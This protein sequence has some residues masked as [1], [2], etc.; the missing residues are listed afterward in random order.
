MLQSLKKQHGANHLLLA[1]EDLRI[2]ASTDPLE[3]TL[4]KHLKIKIIESLESKKTVSTGLYFC[5]F[6]ER[7]HIDFISPIISNK[8]KIIAVIVFQF[9]PEDYL[10]PLIQ[11]WP[12]ESKTAETLLFRIESKSVL[13]LNELRHKKNTALKMSIPLSKTEVPAVA[14]ALG[15]RGAY[16]GYDYRGKE[17][18]AYLDEVP[19]TNWYMTAKV[20]TEEIFSQLKF[21]LAGVI[22]F[23]IVLI[24]ALTIGLMWIYHYR[25]KNIYKTLWEKN[26]EFNITLSSIGDA[27]ITTDN[28]GIIYYINPA[29]EDLTGWKLT[30][31]RGEKIER[32]FKIINEE[33]LA[34]VESPVSKVLREGVVV[35]LA[36]HTLLI[37]KDGKEIPI[38]DSGAPIKTKSGETL[39]VVLVFSDQTDER[40]AQKEIARLNRVYA[41]LSNINE[42]IV[43]IKDRKELFDKACQTAVRDGKFR[44]AWIGIV[45]SSS[46]AV[47]AAAIAGIEENYFKQ[48]NIS[49][50][51]A[52]SCKC[53][54][55]RA[56]ETGSHVINNNLEEESST[57]KCRDEAIYLG[58]KSS[59]SFPIKVFGKTIGA[60]SIYSTEPDFFSESE[61]VLLDEV[62]TDIS[63]ALETFQSEIERKISERKFQEIFN[64]TNEAIFINDANTGK[65]ID[66]NQTTVEMCGYNSKEEIINGNIGDLSANI[67]PYNEEMA[68]RQI[69]K[70]IKDGSITFDWLA[71]RK[72]G[73][74]FWVS[75]SLKKTDI[76]GEA[77]IIATVR[78]ISERKHME[79]N[80][81]NI[82]DFQNTLL[83][84]I[85]FGIDIVDEAG[86]ILF[87]SEKFQKLF[88]KDYLGKKCWELYRDNKTRCE[89][90]PLKDEIKVNET[91]AVEVTRVMNNRIYKI[92]HTGMTFKG[93]PAVL[94]V[95]EDITEQKHA[96][97]EKFR[98]VDIVENSVNEIYL[99]D[100]S[101]MKFEFVNKGALKNLGYTIEEI[102]KM[103]PLDIKPELSREKF[104]QLIEPLTAGREESI[105][106]ETH[107]KR[108]NGT[109]YPVEVYL[110]LFKYDD[111]SLFFAV[112][113]DI[114][115]RKKAQEKII[116]LTQAI[117]QSPVTVMITNPM[118]E[119]EYVNPKFTQLT[120]Y[121]SGEVIGKNPRILQSGDKSKK[122]YAELWDTI[123]SGRKWH[124]E[125][126]N[127]KKNGELFWERAIIS[128]ILNENGDITNFVAVKEDITEIKAVRE[129]IKRSE[130]LFRST[131]EKSF[132]GMRLTD[133][134]GIIVEVNDAFCKMFNKGRN[135]L[136]GKSMMSVYGDVAGDAIEKYKLKFVKESIK[137]E[138]VTK[139]VL[140]T[141]ESKWF[142]L[143]NSHIVTGEG[144]K[145]LMSIFR[146]ISNQKRYEEELIIA[147]ER[148]EQSDRLK[149]E[150]LAQMSHEIR[151][152]LNAILSGANVIKE[153]I[154]EKVDKDY[155][156]IFVGIESSSKRII[157]TIDLIL[158]IA[159]IQSGGFMP[160]NRS[161]DLDK[162]VLSILYNEYL[163]AAKRQN[164]ELNYIKKTEQ[165]NIISDGYCLNQI[166]ANLID[167]AIKYTNKG[168]VVIRLLNDD[169]GKLNVEIEDTGIGISKEY[170]KKMFVPFSQEA[171][172]YSREYDG[173][174]LGLALV[175]KYCEF[176]GIAIEVVSE[177]N[178][179]TIF[180]LK[181]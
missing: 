125:F 151:T 119:I 96:E 82:N 116:K 67:D 15:Q 77:R 121:S 12:V 169:A 94:E 155:Q 53:F 66:C 56:I 22:S 68:Q 168:R 35:G 30:E 166:F 126:H 108:K 159:E 72:N 156:N 79:E 131:W 146:D 163:S 127:K 97:A 40:K 4:S 107:H 10:F 32:V 78:D 26:E 95:F 89:K 20:D 16:I 42:A 170:Q 99:F 113:N 130:E 14:A 104:E 63:F 11:N 176:N 84:T 100:S 124:G 8:G 153:E 2:I 129:R 27:V 70:A 31:A 29:A 46:G 118:S 87:L 181:F 47:E 122:D 83:Q 3:K 48:S 160:H 60:F 142:S 158:N 133:E 9:E 90:C 62:A 150:F 149:S 37:S 34:K 7:I 49:L 144:K 172:G 173:N 180:R 81:E 41:L 21:Q 98:L 143:S 58:C 93:K 69:Q 74:T 132:D 55:E 135:D 75:V 91:K 140:W 103:T 19:G 134:N 136:I 145:L 137:P 128:P 174:G 73:E 106:F 64:S 178:I 141:G 28:K 38:T 117:E 76:A 164:L 23:A 123:L 101:T 152:P 154:E 147:K 50:S 54:V 114:T 25:Q 24:F 110:Q 109:L 177:K 5:E 86:N 36:N 111:T 33:T 6:H 61:I 105:F 51:S 43:R 165:T 167:N 179:G 115:E 13:Y 52:K 80:L 17:V 148:A 85:P 57:L 171:H 71:K 45:N 102:K 120:G 138:L 175:K 59:A 112:I 162:D 157:R 39:G 18:L 139:A 44:L 65:I 1:G 88:G 92:I 161:I